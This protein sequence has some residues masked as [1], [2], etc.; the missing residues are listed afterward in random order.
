MTYVGSTDRFIYTLA[1]DTEG[2]LYGLNYDGGLCTINK[3]TGAIEDVV[4]TNFLVESAMQ[5]M[6]FD[7]RTGRVFWAAVVG[8][9]YGRLIEINPVT[10]ASVDLGD[11]GHNSQI[12]ALYS[13][14]L[15]L[16]VPNINAEPIALYPNPSNGVVHLSPLPEHS[17]IRI[18]DL[19]GKT[20]YLNHEQSGDVTLYLKLKTGAYSVIIENKGM[21]TIHKLIINAN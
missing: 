20:V 14:G 1:A 17:T 5:S 15:G 11:L 10:G 9:H 21:K 7:S 6:T 2:N 19:L 16:S 18:I 4:Q 3:Q 12:T 13:P 8:G